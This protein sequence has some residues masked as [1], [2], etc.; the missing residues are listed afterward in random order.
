MPVH[1]SVT[2]QYSVDT[3]TH[4]LKLLSPSGSHTTLIFA[5]QTVW[6]YRL[7]VEYMGDMKKLLFSTSIS[8]YIGTNTRHNN[9]EDK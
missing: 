3:V 7:G 4:I 5:Y 2:S 6:Q 9:M 1:P 8:L